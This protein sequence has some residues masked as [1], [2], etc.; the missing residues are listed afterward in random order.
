MHLNKQNMHLNK[1][2][3]HLNKQN[4][5]LISLHKIITEN[6]KFKH[7]DS[8]VHLYLTY[9]QYKVISRMCKP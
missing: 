4:M 1:Q 3:M 5:H 2:N 6:C 8:L 7:R 9:S